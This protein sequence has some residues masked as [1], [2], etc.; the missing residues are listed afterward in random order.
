MK[1]LM[2]LAAVAALASGAWAGDV[3]SYAFNFGVHGLPEDFAFH[4]N[5]GVYLIDASN[6]ENLKLLAY[7]TVYDD[8]YTAAGNAWST[9]SRTHDDT[10]SIAGV[11]KDANN[12][13]Q[14][15]GYSVTLDNH[16]LQSGMLMATGGN[17]LNFYGSVAPA[18]N[19]NPFSN[20]DASNLMAL[21]WTPAD[22]KNPEV[23]LLA[24]EISYTGTVSDYGVTASFF[25]PTPE[26][27]SALLLLLGVAGLAL[28]RK[29]A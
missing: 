12:H 1:K 19:E 24:K 22:E 28:K 25:Y 6:S 16:T 10:M 4:G 11:K 2:V 17:Q 18:N 21:I 3:F 14:I 23:T 26:P 20:V 15:G 8:S 27:T 5:T 7:T 13:Y 29:Q 9:S